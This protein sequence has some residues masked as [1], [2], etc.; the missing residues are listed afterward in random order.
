MILWSVPMHDVNVDWISK[1]VQ[2]KKSIDRS[3]KLI[4]LFTWIIKRLDLN[5]YGIRRYRHD[6]ISL[7]FMSLWTLLSILHNLLV[8]MPKLSLIK[9]TLSFKLRNE[10]QKVILFS[11]K[12]F[13]LTQVRHG[14]LL[15]AFTHLYVIQD[16]VIFFLLFILYSCFHAK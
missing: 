15:K 9:F 1:L 12:T 2:L 11:R 4:P 6:T 16:Y 14:N 7:Y 13:Y 3:T 8:P 10:N 5:L